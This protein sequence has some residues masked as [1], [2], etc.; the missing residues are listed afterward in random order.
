MVIWRGIK[1]ETRL[2]LVFILLSPKPIFKHY[3][4]V[5]VTSFCVGKGWK[6]ISEEIA[7]PGEIERLMEPF[8]DRVDH[9]IDSHYMKLRELAVNFEDLSSRSIKQIR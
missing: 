1:N 2:S 9:Q 4:G 6:P 3:C 5:S 8:M 7:D